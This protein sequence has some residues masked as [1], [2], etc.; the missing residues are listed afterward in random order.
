MVYLKI[1][2]LLENRPVFSFLI[3]MDEVN[4][5]ETKKFTTLDEGLQILERLK[6]LAGNDS[7]RFLPIETWLKDVFQKGF[8]T[9]R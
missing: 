7:K 1:R 4:W 3:S 6:I 8:R 9:Y 2:I 5:M